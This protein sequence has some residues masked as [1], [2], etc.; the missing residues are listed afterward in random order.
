MCRYLQNTQN[1]SMVHR[2]IDGDDIAIATFFFN[3]K[4]KTHTHS[5]YLKFFRA[6]AIWIFVR[7]LFSGETKRVRERKKM[8]SIQLQVVLLTNKRYCSYRLAANK[9]LKYFCVG[10]IELLF[11]NSHPAL[12]LLID[13]ITVKNDQNR[14]NLQIK[15]IKTFYPITHTHTHTYMVCALSNA[16]LI[17]TRIG[18]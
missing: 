5:I 14:N 11:L 6:K 16:I 4:H 15:K 10:V 18:W 7:L 9:R 13:H 17:T 3:I 1:E 2:P 12:S 8:R